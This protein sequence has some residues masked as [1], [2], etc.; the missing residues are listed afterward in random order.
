MRKYI[1]TEKANYEETIQKWP[2]M[3][4]EFVEWIDGN[5]EGMSKF[6]YKTFNELAKKFWEELRRLTGV[7]VKCT[8]KDICTV[9]LV[10]F[11]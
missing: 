6:L 11:L 9:V 8:L 4:S 3:E 5:S 1:W 2:F 10:S 7:L